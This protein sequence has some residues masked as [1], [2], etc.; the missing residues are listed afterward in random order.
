MCSPLMLITAAAVKLDSPGPVIFRGRRLGRHGVPFYLLKF[1][2]MQD[3][4]VPVDCSVGKGDARITRV[5]SI[6]RRTKID[7][8][9]QL[10]NVV[11]GHMSIVG[12]RPEMVR[13]AHTFTGEFAEILDA[14]PGLTDPATLKFPNVEE[15]LGSTDPDRVYEEV[16]LPMKNVLRLSYVRN[17]SFWSDMMIV[18]A[19]IL[20]LAK[21]VLRIIPFAGMKVSQS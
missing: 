10:I 16:V 2:S 8:L 5:G 6:I 17:Q 7:E 20:H 11:M 14:L 18:A 13:Y 15:A 3:V 4:E 1:R 9:P 21:S 12:P 19:T